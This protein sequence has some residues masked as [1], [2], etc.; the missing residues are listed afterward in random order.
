MGRNQEVAATPGHY[1]EE[2]GGVRAEEVM[3]LART[4]VVEE[5]PVEV[6]MVLV[7]SL[8]EEEM[9]VELEM[10]LVRSLAEA[11]KASLAVGE[12]ET[13]EEEGTALAWAAQARE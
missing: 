4:Q 1:W 6:E 8:A 2:A 7:R 12:T 9:P 11:G 3:A 13:E 10:V 5:M